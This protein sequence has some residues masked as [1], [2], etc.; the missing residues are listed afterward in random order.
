MAE[1]ATLILGRSTQDGFDER[2]RHALNRS[3]SKR[4]INQQHMNHMVMTI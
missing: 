1:R 2:P 4:T 3:S